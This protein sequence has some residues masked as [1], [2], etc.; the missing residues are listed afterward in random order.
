M[1][2][3]DTLLRVR[4]D[5]KQAVRGLAPLQAS[6][7]ATAADAGKT[8]KA[9]AELDGTH[10]IRL[11]DQAVESA[12]KEITRLRTLMRQQ[13][14]MDP[15]VD[16]RDAQRRIRSLQSAIRSL[17]KEKAVVD[18]TVRVDTTGLATL[19]A[20]LGTVAAEVQGGGSGGLIGGLGAASRASSALGSTSAAAA[21][22]PA[23][24]ALAALAAAKAS[25]ELGEAAGHA[26]TTI[27]QLNAIT[28]GMGEELF[29]D[30]QEWAKVTPFAL[31]DAAAAARRLVASGVEVEDVVDQ[32]NDLGNVA[33][34]A[35]TSVAELAT[36]FAQMRG[37]GK[38]LAEEMQQLAERG[39]PAW[40]ALAD[41]MG[42]SVAQVQ[43]LATDGKLG[44]DA[45]DL[46]RESLNNLYPDAMQQRQQTFEGQMATFKATLEQTAMT[47]GT[48]FLPTMTA[49]IETLNDVLGPL[50]T[51]TEAV[52]DFNANLEETTGL[53]L[54]Q[55]LSPAALVLDLVSGG[56]HD[57][58]EAT[59]STATSVEELAARVV[60]Q[61]R[62]SEDAAAKAKAQADAL[63]HLAEK[64]DNT[65]E[66]YQ[67]LVDSFATVND[68]MTT[69]RGVIYDYEG[70]IDTLA[71]SLV[72]G[73]TFAPDLERGRT[74][75]DA[76]VGFAESA[77]ARV[78]DTWETQGEDAAEAQQRAFRRTLAGMLIDAGHTSDRAWQLVNQVMEEPHHIAL[79]ID[80]IDVAGL[81][82][83]LAR[84][85]K[86]KFKIETT[87]DP[88]TLTPR[89]MDEA[90]LEVQK[91]VKPI[92]VRIRA[93]NERLGAARDELDG[94]ANPKGKD[95]TAKYDAK[96]DPTSVNVAGSI[97]DG[98]AAT[99]IAKVQV[100]VVPPSG[101]PFAGIPGI[102]VQSVAPVP[103]G[104]GPALL[105][106]PVPTAGAWTPTLRAGGGSGAGGGQRQRLAPKQTPVAVYLDGAVIADRLE[107]RRRLAVSE[108]VR[109]TA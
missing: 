1:G 83:Q 3:I 21:A 36:I 86:K 41:S 78:T 58:K 48:L 8:E 4:A 13:L 16:T 65:A 47:L 54:L 45:I 97:L 94:V 84:L 74:N 14:R 80:Q 42:L 99:R 60:E 34:V 107:L 7:K 28:S 79:E 105:A 37:K 101:N 12:R 32:L 51:A 23:A 92:D 73:S 70:A 11:N 6:L 82:A 62:A 43:K 66:R 93:V 27:A 38:I 44:A 9:L 49:L 81:E 67:E 17:D 19:R 106:S 20:A 39:I 35:D 30:L 96:V 22:G 109:R 56:L 33:S 26:E 64:A 46:L 10:T 90:A 103:A 100:V 104:A 52:S 77:S 91:K 88:T 55:G 102:G 98:I 24:L 29:S 18:A 2:T 53:G 63:E 15:Q 85:R 108:S 68:A 31:D 76:L 40:Q 25:W 50:L 72:E 95:R 59:D 69:S 61:T 5:A 75:W 87:L 57:T 89:A 71:K